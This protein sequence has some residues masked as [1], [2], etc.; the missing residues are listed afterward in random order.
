MFIDALHAVLGTVIP[1]HHT[2]AAAAIAAVTS[3]PVCSK[4]LW[5]GSAALTHRCT[6]MRQ[7]FM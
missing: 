3:L 6:L 7:L 5:G 4:C 2:I 1:D